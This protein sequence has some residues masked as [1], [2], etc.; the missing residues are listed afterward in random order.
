MPTLNSGIAATRNC[1]LCGSDD[2]AGVYDLREFSVVRCRHCNLTF[3]LLP[4][5]HA[6]LRNNAECYQVQH[7]GKTYSRARKKFGERYR[8]IL[9]MI[10]AYKSAGRLLDVGCSLGFFLDTARESGFDVYGVEPVKNAAS[11]ARE[12]LKL[13]IT[14]GMLEQ[15]KYPDRFFDIVC[16]FDVLE[17]IPDPLAALAEVSRILKKDGLLVLQCPNIESSMA[18]LT[19][20]HWRWLLVP[21]HLYHFSRETITSLLRKAGYETRDW[22]SYDDEQEFAANLVETRL[23][24]VIP[25]ASM[26]RVRLLI[27]CAILPI[28]RFIVGLRYSNEQKTKGGV[29]LVFASPKV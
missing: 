13:N 3:T 24:R 22:S 15:A 14:T 2:L 10:S 19:K 11:F 6:T 4:D 25:W 8:R 27:T 12:E 9:R 16:L 23:R 28:A 20:Q 1:Y 18:T 29:M 21:Q 5:Q 26:H 17:H 7:W